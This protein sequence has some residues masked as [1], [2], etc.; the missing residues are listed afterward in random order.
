MIPRPD[1][2][3]TLMS[4]LGGFD[5]Y[6]PE[7][8]PRRTRFAVTDAKRLNDSMHSLEAV[9]SCTGLTV[10]EIRMILCLMVYDGLTLVDIERI[11]RMKQSAVSRTYKLLKGKGL[12]QSRYGKKYEVG[13]PYQFISLTVDPSVIIEGASEL[14]RI[15]SEDIGFLGSIDFARDCDDDDGNGE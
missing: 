5:Y 3:M 15:F 12:V 7:V 2:D 10:C 9:L 8:C 14:A 6:D 13:R 1:L 11:T 4:V